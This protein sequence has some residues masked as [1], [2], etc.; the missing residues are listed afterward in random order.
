MR[1]QRAPTQ[2]PR[3]RTLGYAAS[4]RLA[5]ACGGQRMESLSAA[6]FL[7][8]SRGGMSMGQVCGN[9]LQGLLLRDS[10]FGC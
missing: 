5:P 8:P 7:V 4:Q 3:P 2:N 6:R 1:L 9:M 10:K